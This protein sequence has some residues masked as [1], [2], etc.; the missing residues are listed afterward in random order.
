MKYPPR[1]KVSIIRILRAL[2]AQ[3]LESV[4]RKRLRG[5][6]LSRMRVLAKAQEYLSLVRQ[7]EAPR[8]WM[9]RSSLD[10]V[11]A[12]CRRTAESP[13]VECTL[14]LKNVEYLMQAAGFI[15]AIE[16]DP[17]S[18]YLES[19]LNSDKKVEPETKADMLSDVERALHAYE[20]KRN[21]S[22]NLQP[23]Q[24]GRE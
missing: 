6:L 13:R 18:Q 14:R 4:A 5:S 20:E 23:L 12:E 9:G 10:S 11:I 7:A 19:L 16:G 2:I 17:T 15:S 24:S 21:A 22:R 8:P 1:A 3:G